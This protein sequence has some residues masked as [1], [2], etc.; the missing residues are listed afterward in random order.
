MTRAQRTG[1]LSKDIRALQENPDCTK[2][3]LCKY[4]FSVDVYED[5]IGIRSTA[6]W[7]KGNADVP[8]MKEVKTNY[9]ASNEADGV[10]IDVLR[11]QFRYMLKI[12]KIES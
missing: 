5:L 10:I 6:D 2:E 3:P 1:E 8:F 7:A 12:G 9:A 4:I 11:D